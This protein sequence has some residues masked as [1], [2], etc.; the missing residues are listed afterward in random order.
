MSSLG[1]HN[2]AAIVT[3]DLADPLASADAVVITGGT[4]TA[5]G[6]AAD[7]GVTDCD[8]VIDAAG[9]TLAPGLID[10]H[11]HPV[12]GDYTPRQ[13]AS[14]FIA[15]AVHGGVTTMISAGEVHLPGRPADPEG[16]LALAITAERSFR[17]VRPLGAKVRA[18]ALMLEAGLT[19]EHFDRARQAGITLIGEVGVS[20][21]VDPVAVREM[22]G[23]A[24]QRGLRSTVHTGGASVPGSSVIGADFVL[25]VQPDVAAHVNGGPTALPIEDV[26]ALLGAPELR[27][28][29]VHNG[30]VR[31]LRDTVTVIAE[32]GALHRLVVGTD[33]PSGTGVV[34]LGMLRTV[35]LASSLGGVPAAQAWALAT[36][37]TA[38][39]HD[40]DRGRIRP[41]L[42][43]DVVLLDAPV[44]S[45]AGDALS[46]L[47][48]GDTPAVAVVII[49]GEVRLAGSRNTPPPKRTPAV[50]GHHPAGH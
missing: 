40:L 42:A 6:S 14:G 23:W 37:N 48:H 8:L 3:G 50:P 34:P 16:I 32:H 19:P 17:S 39:L 13:S 27:L 38:D 49:D 36:G 35:S 5:V 12:I 20:R 11:L 29:I 22:L 30:N 45:V 41:G 24:R 18:G 26:R 28:E 44:G 2:L 43:G 31:A 47:A 4:I 33:M 25:E 9:L 7:L 15:G 21:L 10:S 1:I 46:A